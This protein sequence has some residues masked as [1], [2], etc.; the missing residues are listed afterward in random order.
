VRVRMRGA[1]LGAFSH[2]GENEGS[3]PWGDMG[4]G[5]VGWPLLARLRLPAQGVLLEDAS[6]L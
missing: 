6:E 1:F 3:F 5:E 2:A 4:R